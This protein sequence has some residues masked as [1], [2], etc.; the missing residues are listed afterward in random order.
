MIA[1]HL[2]ESRIRLEN[3]YLLWKRK[4]ED[5]PKSRFARCFPRV[6]AVFRETVRDTD[7]EFVVAVAR[8]LAAMYVNKHD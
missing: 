5:E 3:I 2:N 6:E 4:A 8:Q 1:M 7:A